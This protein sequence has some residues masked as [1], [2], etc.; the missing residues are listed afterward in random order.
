MRDSL[1]SG[2]VVVA[3]LLCV[4]AVILNYVL[5]YTDISAWQYEQALTKWRS[6]NVFEYRIV[7]D[8]SSM[9]WA[10]EWEMHV[11]HGKVLSAS[12]VG[13]RSGVS[14]PNLSTDQLESLRQFTVE[15]QFERVARMLAHGPVSLE[16]RC[17]ITFDQSLGYPRSI[18]CH[19][20]PWYDV[21]D[22]DT[23]TKV[24]DLEIIKGSNS[25]QP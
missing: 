3:V 20:K 25:T 13:S 5:F 15:G 23:W 7:V 8:N 10:G 6:R 22:A 19:P 21:T 18:E 2:F 12:R 24:T 4:M 9:G 17:S 14:Y 1:K 11:D 16:S